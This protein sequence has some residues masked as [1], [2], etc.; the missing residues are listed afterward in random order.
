MTGVRSLLGRA[1][2][3]PAWAYGAATLALGALAYASR[4][5]TLSHPAA[6][7]AA[8][9][10]LA[11]AALLLTLGY[12]R[13]LDEAAREAHK[14]AWYWGGSSGLL[15]AGLLAMVLVRTGSPWLD[16]LIGPAPSAVT[17]I[18]TGGLG[19]IVPQLVG[20]AVAWAGWWVLR[21]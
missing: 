20:Y 6:A 7:A 2:R 15:A 17:L 19:V 13:A 1:A 18:L 3:L 21:R 8:T 10:G 11:A 16:A 5:M 4:A 12:W 14:F 9:F